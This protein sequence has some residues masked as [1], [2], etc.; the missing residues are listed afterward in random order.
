MKLSYDHTKN[1]NDSPYKA[2]IGHGEVCH[3]SF[4]VSA[5]AFAGFLLEVNKISLFFALIES[6]EGFF[7]A[8]PVRTEIIVAMDEFPWLLKNR[9]DPR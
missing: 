5:S 8:A 6:L 4:L 2:K 7:A 3:D 9:H 1:K